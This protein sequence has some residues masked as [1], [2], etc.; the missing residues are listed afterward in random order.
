[1]F[2]V[3][4]NFKSQVQQL[5]EQHLL[6]LE[7][8]LQQRGVTLLSRHITFSVLFQGHWKAAVNGHTF[9]LKISTTGN[10]LVPQLPDWNNTPNHYQV[11]KDLDSLVAA[12]KKIV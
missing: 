5:A 12:I 9:E 8:E 6:T 1:M 3:G 11:S 10:R 7:A 4:A 2:P